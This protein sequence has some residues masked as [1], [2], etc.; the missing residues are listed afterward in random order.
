[1]AVSFPNWRKETDTQIQEAQG[2]PKRDEDTHTMT[3]YNSNVKTRKD[4]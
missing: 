3:C 4:S 2:V 1:M